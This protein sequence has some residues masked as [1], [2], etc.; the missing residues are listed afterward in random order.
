MSSQRWQWQFVI[1][2]DLDRRTDP[3]KPPGDNP[4]PPGGAGVNPGA[5]GG[6][7]WSELDVHFRGREGD[8]EYQH[9]ETVSHCG[10]TRSSAAQFG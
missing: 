8:M 5:T 4:Y 2:A 10:F 7:S 6:E 9:L 3:R 1:G